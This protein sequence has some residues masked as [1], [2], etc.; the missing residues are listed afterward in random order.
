[1]P[2]PDADLRIA[3]DRQRT[4][5]RDTSQNVRLIAGPGCGKSGAI[6]DRVYWL[7]AVE[8]KAPE[9]IY[10]ISFTRASTADLRE[11]IDRYSATAGVD[12]SDVRVATV[13]SLALRLL[14]RAGLL[15][16]FPVSPSVLD[17]W[18]LDN[19]F[20]SEMADESGIRPTRCET[21]RRHHEAFWSTGVWDPPNYITPDPPVSNA[22]LDGFEATHTPFTE[23][24]A[25]VLPGEMVRE[26]VQEIDSG[27][28]KLA[29]LIQVEELIVDEYQDLNPFDQAFVER[30]TRAGVRTFIG[31]DDDQSIYSFRF[32]S[33]TGIQT[34]V[35]DHP[36]ASD[37]IL[38]GCF[39]STPRITSAAA[40]LIGAHPSPGRIPK[41]LT[42]LYARSAPPVAGEVITLRHGGHKQEANAV[43]RSCADLIDKGV[44]PRQILILL[45][46]RD[47]QGPPLHEALDSAGVPHE[48]PTTERFVDRAGGRA[49]LA[50]LRIAVD[51]DDYV[52]YRTLL[53][54]PRGVGARTCRQ[55]RDSVTDRGENFKD[56]FVG[57]GD[58]S[59]FSRRQRA[60]IE[61]VATILASLVGWTADDE[62]AER[63]DDLVSSV[64]AILGE[65]CAGEV[66]DFLSELPVDIR[67]GELRDYLWAG[68]DEV[69]ARILLKVHQR[70]ERD[71]AETDVLPPRVR[72]MTMHGA[73]GLGAQVVFIPGLE[74]QI[75]PGEKRGPHPGLVLEAARLLYVSITR[76]RAACV[77]SYASG[78]TVF[79][80]WVQHDPTR[81]L[82][83]MG[84]PFTYRATGLSSAEV[85]GILDAIGLL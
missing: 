60:A 71:L 5:A 37:Q 41:N 51:P 10:A 79:G 46:N 75:L 1:M 22:E 27:N 11:R 63:H 68:K 2:I 73:K 76:A 35:A 85:D 61:R 7:L 66:N 17:E 19:I 43:A 53:G 13:H 64:D 32:A 44:A 45:S 21:I 74:D 82:A 12:A 83:S 26:C 65:E 58:L 84:Q 81:F 40:R 56:L 15:S 59:P 29:E 72:V 52:A 62:L 31:G 49:A 77:M 57:L 30:I 14:R 34:F 54:L 23:V 9:A 25:C 50:L 20:T 36:G 18:E 47:I 80:K 6:E 16:R 33:P 70:A 67:L 48:M 55:I 42:S 38:E 3:V 8:G 28:L 78:R 24:Y 39:R 4:V 69:Q